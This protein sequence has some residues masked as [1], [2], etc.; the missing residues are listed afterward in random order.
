MKKTLNLIEHYKRII[1]EQG[2]EEMQQMGGEMEGQEGMEGDVTEMP[3]ELPQEEMPFTSESE[4]QYIEDLIDAALYEP[5][6]EDS[7]TLTDL[8]GIVKMKKFTNAREEILPTLLTIIRPSTEGNDI[9]GE[10]NNI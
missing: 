7:K 1:L 10:L 2:E 8:Q 4:N 3:E 9:R 5:S 6:S